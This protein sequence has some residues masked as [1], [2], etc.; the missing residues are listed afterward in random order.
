MSIF[1]G[2]EDNP[3]PLTPEQINLKTVEALVK[4]ARDKQHSEFEFIRSLTEYKSVLA[5][6]TAVRK[7]AQ[8]FEKTT[9]AIYDTYLKN[10]KGGYTDVKQLLNIQEMERVT[11]FYKEEAVIAM[12]MQDEYMAYLRAGHSI[13]AFLGKYRPEIDLRDFRKPN[14]T[15]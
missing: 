8:K 6:K 13:D 11:E 14:G 2:F 10:V 15:K 5:F 12:D 3:G 7:I 1:E 9:K 4:R